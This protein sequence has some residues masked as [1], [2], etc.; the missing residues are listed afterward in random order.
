M[1][2]LISVKLEA[3]HYQQG[4]SELTY[5]SVNFD[6]EKIGPNGGR[7]LCDWDADPANCTIDPDQLQLCITPDLFTALRGC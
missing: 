5:M 2:S 3:V 6:N 7:L 1:N 4:L